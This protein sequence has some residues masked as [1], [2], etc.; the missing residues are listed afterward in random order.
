MKPMRRNF[1]IGIGLVIVASAIAL[2]FPPVRRLFHPVVLLIQGKQ[3][4]DDR[5]REFSAA[6]AS[7]RAACKEKGVEFP[8][9]RIV[10][11]GLKQERRLEVYVGRAQG[12]LC[13]LFSY[14]ILAA[15]GE[16]GPKLREG[17]RQVPEGVYALESLNPNSRFHVALRVGYPN[18]LDT[19]LARR[20]GRTELGGDI[21]IHGGAASIGCLAMGD[22]AIEEI[23]VLVAE[24]GIGNVKIVLS[25]VDLRV[26]SL[27]AALQAGNEERYA[28]IRSVL[29]E[30]PR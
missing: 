17:D 2:S 8:P 10:L 30:L 7:V 23:F 27:P 4:I 12:P 3:T 29:L 9:S 6:Q 25:P 28:A 15:S 22:T 16:L 26:A 14:P 20:D 24:A 19:A 18:A 13:K 1:G 5:L 21:M 11:L